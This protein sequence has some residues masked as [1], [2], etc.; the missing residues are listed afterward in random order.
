M[1][2]SQQTAA[3]TEQLMFFRQEKGEELV[4]AEDLMGELG[5]RLLFRLAFNDVCAENRARTGEMHM[6]TLHDYDLRKCLQVLLR[7]AKGGGK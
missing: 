1:C 6:Y 3:L 7:L 5:S 4:A 2:C